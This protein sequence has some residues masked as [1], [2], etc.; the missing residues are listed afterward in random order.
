MPHRRR[1]DLIHRRSRHRQKRNSRH[2]QRHHWRTGRLVVLPPLAEQRRLLRRGHGILPPLVRA[3]VQPCGLDE[4]QG[5]EEEG[6]RAECQVRL[7]HLG[8]VPVVS[9][10]ILPPRG[11]REVR[12]EGPDGEAEEADGVDRDEVG[13]DTERAGISSSVVA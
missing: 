13:R 3:V 1:R 12:A 4:G 6:V 5:R 7:G 10:L 11:R 8:E 9:V 2:G